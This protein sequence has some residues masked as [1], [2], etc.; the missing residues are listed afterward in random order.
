MSQE[1]GKQRKRRRGVRRERRGGYGLCEGE[2][3]WEGGRE[4]KC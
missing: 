2:G 1:D 4:G 3:G